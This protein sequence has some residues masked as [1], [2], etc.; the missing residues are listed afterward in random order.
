MATTIDFP[1]SPN[2]DDTYTY[3]DTTFTWS[4]VI[5][6]VPAGHY[7][8]PTG[9]GNLHV[10][11]NGTGNNL[12]FLQSGAVAGTYTW[13]TVP[14]TD[15]VQTDIG[16]GVDVDW[17]LGDVFVKTMTAN[18]TFTFSSL[19]E[20]KTIR[21]V[22]TGD[23]AITFP[24]GII[25][26]EVAGYQGTEYNVYTITCYDSTTPEFSTIFRLHF[27]AFEYTTPTMVGHYL[28]DGSIITFTQKVE[29]GDLLIIVGSSTSINSQT[30]SSLTFPAGYNPLTEQLCTNQYFSGSF[31]YGHAFIEAEY[32][33]C[34][35]TEAQTLSLGSNF[36]VMHY[37]GVAGIVTASTYTNT[38]S[39][40]VSQ[41]TQATTTGYHVAVMGVV[42]YAGAP[43]SSNASNLA[44]LYSSD[45]RA[46][47][48][49]VSPDGG[50]EAYWKIG[51]NNS[52]SSNTF[53][54]TG[55]EF[56]VH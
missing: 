39:I 47:L 41:S 28:S 52:G 56:Y 10:P 26:A 20:G 33:V 6:Y 53:C 42:N 34:D 45:F 3:G 29:L 50:T 31:V 9:D 13:E 27:S 43:V 23:F 5:W 51:R 17:S 7:S 11:A 2:V 30:P 21:L 46:L 54:N 22:I 37:K 19:T 32:R 49:V 44:A 1:A 35:G 40:G 8:H 16:A 15:P 12:K 14:S 25:A 55:I 24:V 18:T 4:G 38:S 36:S 48:G